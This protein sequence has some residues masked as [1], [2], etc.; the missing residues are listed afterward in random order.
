MERKDAAIRLLGRTVRFAHQPEGPDRR[1]DS[2][3]WSGMVTV[4]GMA[5]EFAPHLFVVQEN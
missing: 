1:I 3:G 4:A 2:I 5:G